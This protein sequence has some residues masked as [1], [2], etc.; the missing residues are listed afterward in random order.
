MSISLKIRPI[1]AEIKLWGKG[2]LSILRP[3]NQPLAKLPPKK[4]GLSRKAKKVENIHAHG[5]HTG[6][7][8]N[9]SVLFIIAD[10][11]AQDEDNWKPFVSTGARKIFFRTPSFDSVSAFDTI[12]GAG[13]F[14]SAKDDRPRPTFCTLGS[15]AAPVV[16][17]HY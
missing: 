12:A 7:G 10:R 14:G 8:V 4:T 2:G 11:L 17:Y 16:V 5:S 13:E 15:G 3:V 1:K 6:L 9:P